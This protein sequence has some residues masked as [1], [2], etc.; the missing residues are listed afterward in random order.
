MN[1]KSGHFIGLLLLNIF[2]CSGL[3][4]QG[5]MSIDSIQYY[6]TEAKKDTNAF[7]PHYHLA[8]LYAKAASKEQASEELKIAVKKGAGRDIVFYN[9]LFEILKVTEN[10][11]EIEALLALQYNR[12]NPEITHPE[13][14]YK[15][16]GWYL[17]EEHERNAGM[18]EGKRP[19]PDELSL[20][21]KQMTHRRKQLHKIIEDIGWPGYS[22]VGKRG[23]DA[24][25]FL[26]QHSAPSDIKK[27]LD[28]FIKVATEGDA[29]KAKAA[30]MIDRYLC[31]K[32]GV[33]LYGT[34]A[35][36]KAESRNE[37]S[38]QKLSLYPIANEENLAQRR[39][40]V[41]LPSM[42][43]YCQKLDIPYT[44]VEKRVDYKPIAIK[45]KWI[46]KGFLLG[47]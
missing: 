39:L 46:K 11:S 41:G 21:N 22:Q 20:L 18:F 32:Y 24:A 37:L 27:H 29:D 5:F 17:D 1:R 43:T 26:I 47:T 7:L 28:A 12:E 9:K 4:A 14:G 42:E 13:I 19:T 15:I 30:L 35:T 23:S 31:N 45:K 16:W 34:Q 33:Q 8:R 36:R 25:F 2:L 6:K 44:P 40:S 3:G 38:Q 10:W